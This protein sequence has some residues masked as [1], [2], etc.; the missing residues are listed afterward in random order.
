MQKK[1]VTHAS[2]VKVT[3]SANGTLGHLLYAD[4]DEI[5]LLT[6]AGWIVRLDYSGSFF[7]GDSIYFARTGCTGTPYRYSDNSISGK[8]L[9]YSG[10]AHYKPASSPSNSLP[11]TS[12]SYASPR[13]SNG[14]CTN[15][16]GTAS[17]ATEL[18]NAT[19]AE[20]G[21]PATITGPIVLQTP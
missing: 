10:T 6:T 2:N 19:V 16:S 13:E 14:S 17:K 11:L 4:D 7:V 12:V 18:S 20:T 9:F 3:T 21:L 15:F 5:T 8:S 1:T